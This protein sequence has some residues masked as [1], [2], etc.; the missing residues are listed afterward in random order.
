MAASFFGDMMSPREY[1]LQL[2]PLASDAAE[3][4]LYDDGRAARV[5]NPTSNRKTLGLGSKRLGARAMM[6][7]P[8]RTINHRKPAVSTHAVASWHEGLCLRR[9]SCTPGPAPRQPTGDHHDHLIIM[10][11]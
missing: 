9:P 6:L 3:R 1:E 11:I 2:E 8:H 7:T 4:A 10:I 5:Q